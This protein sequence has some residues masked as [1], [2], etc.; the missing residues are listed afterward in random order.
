[1]S[2]DKIFDLTAGVYF[3]FYNIVIRARSEYHTARKDKFRQNVRS[4]QTAGWSVFS[5]FIILFSR[6]HGD[7]IITH[8]RSCTPTLPA[9]TKHTLTCMHAQKSASHHLAAVNYSIQRFFGV[10]WSALRAPM[11]YEY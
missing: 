8:D 1:M 6:F 3:N 9:R 2:F 11:N 7:Q 4:S 5:F 10:S